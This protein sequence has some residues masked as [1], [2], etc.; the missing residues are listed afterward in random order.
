MNGP[1]KQV[2]EGHR[3]RW[4][5]Q[6]ACRGN[7]RN[8]EPSGAC[9]HMKLF[10]TMDRSLFAMN[11]S[12]LFPNAPKPTFIPSDQVERKTKA[13]KLEAFLLGCRKLELCTSEIAAELGLSVKDISRT[14]NSNA[15]ALLRYNGWELTA[16]NG[17]ASKPILKNNPIEI[18]IEGLTWNN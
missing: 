2:S 7:V 18:N 4:L 11:C 6:M 13:A 1:I 12:T 9:G 3:L 10:T 15:C 5:K 8:A 17:R 16:G 14:F